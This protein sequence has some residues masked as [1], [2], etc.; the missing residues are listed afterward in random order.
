MKSLSIATAVSLHRSTG[1]DVH[2]SNGPRRQEKTSCKAAPES[3]LSIV[4]LLM[5]SSALFLV[6]L[7]SSF[8][9]FKGRTSPRRTSAAPRAGS[10]LESIL[11]KH[12]KHPAKETE[13]RLTFSDRMKL[14]DVGNVLYKDVVIFQEVQVSVTA[15]NEIKDKMATSSNLEEDESLKGCEV[16]VQRHNIQQILKECIVNLCIA[17]PERPMK[18][19]REH[20]EKLEKVSDNAASCSL[21]AV[22]RPSGPKF[23][24]FIFRVVSLNALQRMGTRHRRSV[25]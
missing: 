12:G 13:K 24:V 20:F 3:P 8:R 18:F 2:L 23:T 17:K 7:L 5:A 6:A 9:Q 11:W 1:S 15:S 25:G 19:L 14:I 10:T 22:F 16:F 4:S 21:L